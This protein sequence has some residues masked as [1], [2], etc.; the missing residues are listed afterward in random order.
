MLAP[1]DDYLGQASINLDHVV[2]NLA[3][4]YFITFLGDKQSSDKFGPLVRNGGWIQVTIHSGA[5]PVR[6]N[7]TFFV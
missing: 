7:R 3:T 1:A 4:W 2:P 5:T 6:S